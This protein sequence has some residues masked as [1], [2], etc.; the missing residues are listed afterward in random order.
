MA[1]RT[2]KVYGQAYAASGDVNVVLTVGG[3]EVFNGAVND[4]TTSRSGQPQTENHLFT[5]TLDE[6]TTG[7]LSYSLA[8][9]GGELCLGPTKHNGHKTPIV[10]DSELRTTEWNPPGSAELMEDISTRIGE[11]Y[12]GTDLYNALQAGTA[13]T[14][15][16][17]AVLEAN[18]NGPRNFG[19]TDADIGNCW[20]ERTGAQIDGVDIPGWALADTN[21]QA[22]AIIQ[23][24]ETF[25]CTWKF[26]PDHGVINKWWEKTE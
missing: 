12:L 11:T 10:P 8:V 4:S 15:V 25:T 21:K 14:D 1:N 7:D 6:N 22:W 24:G 23:D 13:G 5:F 9:T 26:D 3:T 17:D 19:T 20:C 18:L 2:F 16:G